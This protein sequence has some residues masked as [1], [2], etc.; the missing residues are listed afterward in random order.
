MARLTV[1][2]ATALLVTSPPA[3]AQSAPQTDVDEVD[4]H[5]RARVGPL[6]PTPMDR[7][8]MA[9]WRRNKRQFF[10]GAN[11]D[12]GFAYARPTLQVGWGRPHYMWT[13][14][15]GMAQVAQNFGGVYLG[16]RAAFPQLEVRA[17][18]RFVRP[19]FHPVQDAKASYDIRDL[20]TERGNPTSYS[21][22]ELEA[23][24]ELRAG[25]GFIVGAFT[26]VAIRGVGDGKEVF[27]ETF[28]VMAA[29][30][31][32]LRARLG[33][34]F[35]AKPLGR[36]R[37]GVAAEVVDVPGRLG[38]SAIVRAGV[39]MMWRLHEQVDVLVQLLPVVHSPDTLGL[40]AADFS[41]LGVRYRW[42]TPDV[43]GPRER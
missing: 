10:V 38:D 23:L 26:A 27:E 8:P 21:L 40:T 42:A 34:M 16:W 29:P 32:I 5:G 4:V 36:S 43:P 15:E 41:Q 18:A 1:L 9:Y 30:P 2:V 31:V 11:V 24:P 20:E 28:R 33:Y 22:Y 6:D 12:V 14:A 3:F 13:G 17:G 19:F 25:P 7:D 39:L 35:D 37:I